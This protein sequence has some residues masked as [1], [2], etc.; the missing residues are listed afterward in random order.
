MDHHDDGVPDV[1]V[2][3][4]GTGAPELHHQDALLL[5]PRVLQRLAQAKHAHH[6][7]EQTC[8]QILH[9]GETSSKPSKVFLNGIIVKRTLIFASSQ[10]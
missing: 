6:Y 7:Q 1:R 10:C 2:H 4:A 5:L 9:P 8:R 3:E